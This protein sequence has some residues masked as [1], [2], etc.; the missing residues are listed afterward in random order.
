MIHS[1]VSR[2][3]TASVAVTLLL[4][5]PSFALA[6]DPLP[7]SGFVP[8]NNQAVG[9]SNEDLNGNGVLDDGEDLNGNGRLD[10]FAAVPAATANLGVFPNWVQPS[11]CING[12]SIQLEGG[13]SVGSQQ[14]YSNGCTVNFV[15]EFFTYGPPNYGD[16]LHVCVGTDTDTNFWPSGSII[17]G[18][19]VSLDSVS[20]KVTVKLF[21]PPSEPL[22]LG[23][24]DFLLTEGQRYN[25]SVKHN[26]NGT[27][28]DTLDVMINDQ[29]VINV[30][31][32]A[33]AEIWGDYV[34][35]HN[36]EPVAGCY[37]WSYLD[38]VGIT[39]LPAPQIPMDPPPAPPMPQPE[40]I[41]MP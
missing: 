35:I 31:I 24:V 11:T 34:H 2:R 18:I 41:P 19:D 6:V 29:L 28:L 5:T 36:R 37:N 13:G 8:G 20:D 22:Q 21:N 1:H 15:W 30:T 32:P 27:A 25:I 12:T 16:T 14:E 3:L 7:P 23:Q 10:G 17:G 40:P 38:N 26:P 9:I 4:A 33:G 39:P